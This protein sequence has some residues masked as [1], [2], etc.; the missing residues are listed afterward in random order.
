MKEG[1]KDSLQ[2]LSGLRYSHVSE[3]SRAQPHGGLE[4]KDRLSRHSFSVSYSTIACAVLSYV[5]ISGLS[6]MDTGSVD[7]LICVSSIR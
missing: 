4:L 6:S 3:I 7:L 5:R 1:R 2:V